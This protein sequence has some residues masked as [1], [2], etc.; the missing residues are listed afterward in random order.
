MPEIKAS[1]SQMG[2]STA[3]D[4]DIRGHHLTIDRPEAKGGGDQGAMGG[5]VL[6]AALGG[7]F[8]SNL[9][10]A[11]KA[12]DLDLRDL[13]VDVVGDL[14][15]TPP[16]Y[17]SIRMRVTASGKDLDQLAK[18]VDMSE[19]ACIVA[20]TLKQGVVVSSGVGEA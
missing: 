3:S 17:Q 6:L 1:V 20:N 10:A 19:R 13:K 2:D 12:R 18:L 15:G 8:M 11:V 16:V 4:A 5:E 7:C 9:I 14:D